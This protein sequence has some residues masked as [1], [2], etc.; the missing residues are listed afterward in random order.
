M[1][2]PRIDL[3]CLYGLLQRAL[4]M[5]SCIRVSLPVH[6]R[7]R[8]IKF[9]GTEPVLR[10]EVLGK[11]VTKEHNTCS[12]QQKKNATTRVCRNIDEKFR[13]PMFVEIVVCRHA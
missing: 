6:A 4:I 8:M 2:A 12:E 5:L 10:S 7:Q 9:L 3:V 1:V 11:N 13:H